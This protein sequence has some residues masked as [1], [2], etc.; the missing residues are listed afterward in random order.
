[1]QNIGSIYNDIHNS[2]QKLE[3]LREDSIMIRE[4]KFIK[5]FLNIM[6]KMSS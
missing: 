6:N 3:G 4:K 2:F 1:M 5:S